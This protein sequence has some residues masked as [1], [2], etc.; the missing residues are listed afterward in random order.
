MATAPSAVPS[1]CLARHVRAYLKN[2]TVPASH[3]KCKVDGAY[4]PKREVAVQAVAAGLFADAEDRRIYI[5]Q[6]ELARGWW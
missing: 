4:F 3:T 1:I 2:G 6:V 5:A